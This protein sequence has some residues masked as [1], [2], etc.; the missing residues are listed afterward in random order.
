VSFADWVRMDRTYIGRQSLWQDI[1]LI[2][3]TV[4]SVLMRRGA[5]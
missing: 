5:K 4:P 2:V 3:M 1:K